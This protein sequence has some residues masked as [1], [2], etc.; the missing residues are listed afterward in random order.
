[1]PDKG[2]WIAETFEQHVEG[3][4]LVALGK[5]PVMLGH[6]Q[7]YMRI[8]RMLEAE[9]RLQIHLL[10]R[11]AKQVDAAYDGGHA[12]LGVVDHHGELIGERAI[13]APDEK[14]SAI[15]CKILLVAAL[16]AV[17]ERDRFV[18]DEQALRR[19][20]QRRP[21]GSSRLVEPAACP[22]IDELFTVMRGGS[23]MEVG[24]RAE[25]RIDQV[26]ASKL[27]ESR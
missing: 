8:R 24:A 16:D 3:R 5:A 17:D 21:F 7:R 14:I 18:R 12:L 22:R 11:G 13:R 15:A 10:G 25:A 9:K 20:A 23:R 19:R 27:L 1:M 26:A 4:I 2:A 6:H